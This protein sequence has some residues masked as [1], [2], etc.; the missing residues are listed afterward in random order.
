MP[1]ILN[2]ELF[3]TV[4]PLL[5]SIPEISRVPLFVK[6]PPV[7]SRVPNTLNSLP[8]LFVVTLPLPEFV[9]EPPTLIVLFEVFEIIEEFITE[10]VMESVPSLVTLP[11]PLLVSS[12]P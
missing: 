8:A 7:V 3:A 11:V 10:P 1:E 12:P 6:V 5:V 4:P 9:N 2:T